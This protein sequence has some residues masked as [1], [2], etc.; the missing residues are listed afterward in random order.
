MKTN[1]MQW[2][3]LTAVV[4][5]LS[6]SAFALAPS[7]AAASG[8]EQ[9][10]PIGGRGGQTGAFNGGRNATARMPLTALDPA[11]VEALNR[12]VLEEYGALNTYQAVLDQFGDVYPFNRI[13]RSET[14]HVT[15]LTRLLTRYGQAVPA[16]PGLYPAPTWSSLTA[17]C[18]TG[19]DAEIA[20]AKLYDELMPLTDSPDL[21][22][23]FTNLQAASL[24][25]HL[26][27]FEAC[28]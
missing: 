21:I 19:V 18:Q 17:A 26:L 4:V 11:E 14:Q 12:A 20:D 24:N 16:N 10:G 28:N 6:V 13:V 3:V 22:R 5:A 23:V 25:N 9:G 2:A 15:A 7:T 1:M 27:A 8:L